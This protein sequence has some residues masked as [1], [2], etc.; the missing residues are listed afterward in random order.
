MH[1]CDLC[2]LREKR[3]KQLV[4]LYHSF[5]IAK[6]SSEKTYKKVVLGNFCDGL[7]LSQ[8]QVSFALISA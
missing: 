4:T 2:F 1:S 6:K 3:A 8:A 7:W 5:N